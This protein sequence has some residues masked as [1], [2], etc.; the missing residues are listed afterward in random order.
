MAR[1]HALLEAIPGSSGLAASRQVHGTSLA[2]HDAVQGVVILEGTDGHATSTPGTVL[3]VTAADC[4]P[5]YILDPVARRAALLHAGWRG[6]AARILSLGVSLLKARGSDSSTLLMHCGI[7]ICGG[8]YEV[9]SEVFASCGL[10][11]PAGG[12]GQLDLRSV[13]ADQA[14]QEGIREISTSSWCSAHHSEH[15]FSHRRSGGADGRMVAYLSLC[16]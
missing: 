12:K 11:T 7:G 2:W 15:F 1:W 14:R 5:V 4:V 13:L 9:S 10:P 8:C 16:A 6:T 3:A